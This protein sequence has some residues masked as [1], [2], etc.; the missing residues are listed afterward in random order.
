MA[1]AEADTDNR[2][3][4]ATLASFKGQIS[5][6]HNI[7]S[8]ETSF[9]FFVICPNISLCFGI[10][11]GLSFICLFIWIE[12]FLAVFSLYSFYTLKSERL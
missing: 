2:R 3:G 9:N 8:Q 1:T 4:K 12:F 10:L 11:R 6:V 7:E 5:Y